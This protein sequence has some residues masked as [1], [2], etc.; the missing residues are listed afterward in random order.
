MAERIRPV[1]C[2][3]WLVASP[4]LSSSADSSRARGLESGGPPS[5]VRLTVAFSN[6]SWVKGDTY[7]GS[8][9][10]LLPAVMPRLFS[11]K[12]K[13]ATRSVDFVS[14]F[15]CSRKAISSAWSVAVNSGICSDKSV[16]SPRSLPRS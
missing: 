6:Y 15:A 4:S 8:I 5:G 7:S 3:A 12:L 2:D 10:F 13:S 1:G 11:N 9:I 16:V 14:A